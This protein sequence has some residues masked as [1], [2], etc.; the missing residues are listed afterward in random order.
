MWVSLGVTLKQRVAARVRG[1]ISQLL[2]V[3]AL[4]G[5]FAGVA[6]GT[7]IALTQ[8]EIDTLWPQL[9]DDASSGDTGTTETAAPITTEAPG[10]AP[11]TDGRPAAE[12]ATTALIEQ[13][14]AEAAI[15][16]LLKTP[17]DVP[18]PPALGV[19]CEDDAV[20]Q[21]LTGEL[22]AAW[23]RAASEPEAGLLI[24]LNAARR[25]LQLLGLDD[26]TTYDLE[27]RLADRLGAKARALMQ[28]NQKN[29]DAI[30]AVIGFVRKAAQLSD[31]LGNTPTAVGLVDVLGAWLDPFVPDMLRELKSA[32]DYT[33]ATTVVRLVRGLNSLGVETGSANLESVL[34]RIAAAMHFQLT[35]D[36]Q[37]TLTGEN[38]HVESYHLRA[39]IPLA[40][41][42]G[43]SERETRAM[44]VG[45][46]TGHY[47]SYT[48]PDGDLGMLPASFQVG[49]KVENFDACAGTATLFLDRFYAD[50]E[51]YT[52]R[53]GDPAMLSGGMYGWLAAWEEYRANGGY[54][55]DLEV[56]NKSAVAIDATLSGGQG[57]FVGV[58]KVTLEHQPK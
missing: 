44:L 38:G 41:E 48:D 32:H 46:A 36:Y 28:A 29:R 58:L 54:V 4:T 50:A 39:D 53:N 42:I 11:A 13:A 30:P 8:D 27:T 37:F 20:T 23:V 6:P 57:A 49:A 14:N 24:R 55:F 3:C 18:M 56:T 25:S 31:L 45:E 9:P 17:S 12:R 40:F 2:L 43:G 35:V 52:F 26:G 21:M 51:T 47:I 5:W 1:S 34:A 7:A 10:A 22:V 16:A 15:R 19:S 33:M